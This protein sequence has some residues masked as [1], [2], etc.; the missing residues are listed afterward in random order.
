MSSEDAN[1]HSYRDSGILADQKT[2][3]DARLWQSLPEPI[4]GV[5]RTASEHDAWLRQSL[6]HL[7]STEQSQS[8]SADV[9]ETIAEHERLRQ[10]LGQLLSTRQSQSESANVDE[11]IAE[12]DARLR[13]SLQHLL[14]ITPRALQSPEQQRDQT[15]S[16]RVLPDLAVARAWMSLV[17]LTSK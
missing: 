10:S 11:T 12:H 3:G 2:Q 14:S 15:V 5:G 1:L 7:L 17:I 9:D 8:E 4:E 13:K 6:K 16:W